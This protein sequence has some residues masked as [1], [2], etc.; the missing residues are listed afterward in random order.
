MTNAELKSRAKSSLKGCRITAIAVEV[1][2]ALII[3]VGQLLGLLAPVYMILVFG[4][5]CYGRRS[6]YLHLSKGER[7]GVGRMF[8]GFSNYGNTMLLN[9]MIMVFSF[10]W[11]L[12]LVIPGVIKMLSYSMAFY[13]LDENP[14]M[15]AGE[16]LNRSKKMM[17]GHKMELFLLNLSFIGWVFL[18][19]VTLGIGFLYTV[20]YMESTVAQFYQKLSGSADNN[21]KKL[22]E[23]TG[24]SSMPEEVRQQCSGSMSGT[25]VL[26]QSPTTTLLTTAAPDQTASDEEVCG[27]F[28]GLSGGLK[29]QEYGMPNG[30]EIIVGRDADQ[31]SVL[32]GTDNVSISRRHC[33]L[34]YHAR[35]DRYEVQDISSNGV[36]LADGSRMQKNTVQMLPRGTVLYLGDRSESFRLD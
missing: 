33:I 17:D 24:V 1:L 8:S 34:R 29:G 28:T 26:N 31:C 14:D 4:P 35:Q 21:R 23:E 32:T 2:M 9:L 3:G 6:Y 36:Y 7:P 15:T 18:S 30:M 5:I 25:V 22:P 16:A 10:L 13:I 11:S 19:I 27:I 12:L 20:P